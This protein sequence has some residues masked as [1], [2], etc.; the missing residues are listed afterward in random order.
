MAKYVVG[1]DFVAKHW[2][3]FP[4]WQVASVFVPDSQRDVW[5]DWLALQNE[6]LL[7]SNLVEETPRAAKLAWWAEELRGWSRGLRRHPLGVSLQSASSHWADLAAVLQANLDLGELANACAQVSSD[8]SGY[9]VSATDAHAL[10][11]AE[12]DL[13]A[14]RSISSALPKS[15]GLPRIMALQSAILAARKGRADVAKPLAPMHALLIC[16]NAARKSR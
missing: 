3:R 8:L 10:L 14:E 9:G 6:L 16:W 15:S 12:N 7:A 4:E 2:Q 1:N 11:G 13:I 5:F